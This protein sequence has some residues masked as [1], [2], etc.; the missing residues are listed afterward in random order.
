MIETTYLCTVC[1][2]DHVHRFAD[3]FL[4]FRAW[5]ETC[6]HCR[7]RAVCRLTRLVVGGVVKRMTLWAGLTRSGIAA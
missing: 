6:P 5:E 3:G 2:R 7:R 4:P 1:R